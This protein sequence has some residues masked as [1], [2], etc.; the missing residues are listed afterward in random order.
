MR[1][2]IIERGLPTIGSAARQALR[3]GVQKSYA[4]LKEPSLDIQWVESYVPSDKTF[5]VYLARDE[6]I[7]QGARQAQRLPG[8]Q[9]HRNSPDDR[10]RRPLPNGINPSPRESGGARAES[11]VT[12]PRYPLTRA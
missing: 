9:D 10:P 2:F 5:C 4:T 1:K 12:A 11:E 6:A 8:E 7:I 3:E